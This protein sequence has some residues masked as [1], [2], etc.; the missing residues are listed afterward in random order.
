MPPKKTN[1]D[2]V[3]LK[4]KRQ[5]STYILDLNVKDTVATIKEKLVV[6]INST[7]GLKIIDNPISLDLQSSLEHNEA[8]KDIAIPKIGLNDSSDSDS[9]NDNNDD[10]DD[11][12]NDTKSTATEINNNSNIRVTTDDIFLGKFENSN[13]IYDSKIIEFDEL[14]STKLGKLQLQDFTTFAFKLKSEDFKI[15]KPQYDL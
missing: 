14:D 12:N 10:D 5:S 3:I 1:T 11:L 9:N 7:N 4:L 6:L 8:D 15:Y 13:D 2:L